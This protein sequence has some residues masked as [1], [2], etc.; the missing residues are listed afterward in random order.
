MSIKQEDSSE[1]KMKSYSSFSHRG[2][3]S[4]AKIQCK[5]GVLN[6]KRF[7]VGRNPQTELLSLEHEEQVYES[8]TTFQCYTS[9]Q[10]NLRRILNIIF[11]FEDQ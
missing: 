1:K 11:C 10:E 6:K 5:W 7:G 3:R 4:M 2:E 8:Y 9:C